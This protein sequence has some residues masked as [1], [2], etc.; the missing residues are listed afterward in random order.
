MVLTSK[1]V[2]R[3]ALIVGMGAIPAQAQQPS[4]AP[5][6]GDIRPLLYG[7]ALECVDCRPGEGGRGRSGGG[8]PP[9]L[10]YRSFPHV[11]AVAPGSAAEQADIRAGDILRSID[12]ISVIS[13]S[14]AQRL[15]RAH[16]GQQVRLAFERDA[17]PVV[18]SLKLG[19]AS[20]EKTGRGPKRIFGGY[21]AMQG[22]IHGNVKLEIWSDEAIVPGD[23]VVQKATASSD[24][25]GTVVLRIGNNTL[26]RLQLT[27]ESA[28]LIKRQ[29]QDGAPTKP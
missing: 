29:D 28:D 3:L 27:K 26:I 18:V 2:T 22:S 1:R 25:T 11:I 24:S 14:G 20:P 12:G 8:Q 5:R 4:P 13:D 9:V 10:S 19:A 17:K 7:F 23:L 21:T 15:A 16:A 6:S